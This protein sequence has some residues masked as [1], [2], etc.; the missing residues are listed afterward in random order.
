VPGAGWA[1]DRAGFRA[2]LRGQIDV[3]AV[4]N[5]V[6]KLI[7]SDGSASNHQIDSHAFVRLG[8][9]AS[10]DRISTLYRRVAAEPF[11]ADF[12][13]A[14][15]YDQF[16]RASTVIPFTV[17][18]ASNA[19]IF[20]C[21]AD[22]SDITLLFYHIR[23]NID[24]LPLEDGIVILMQSNRNRD[25]VIG[26]F[27]E[28][29]RTSMQRCSLFIVNDINMAAYSL[30]TVLQ[31]AEIENFAF[32][33]ASTM[34]TD[35][36]WDCASEMDGSLRFMEA[37]D[38][39]GPDPSAGRSSF[40]CFAWSAPGWR[41]HMGHNPPLC[42]GAGMLEPDVQGLGAIEVSNAATLTQIAAPSSFAEAVNNSVRAMPR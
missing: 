14:V 16:I 9:A 38:P 1:L 4:E 33:G 22:E 26:L 40:D 6:L 37:C 39:A 42:G 29:S 19:V 20:A 5:S 18:A 17:E 30:F 12:A 35:V 7:Y 21:P 11:F 13:R 3:H 10:Y 31:Q 23:R 28:L 27:D 36:G 2:V 8:I 24:R 41:G 32:V 25:V 15:C 34:L